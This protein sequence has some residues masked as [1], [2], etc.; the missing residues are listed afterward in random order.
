MIVIIGEEEAI[1]NA[2]LRAAELMVVSAKTAPKARG[3]DNVVSL[4]I[5]DKDVLEKLAVKMEELSLLH[6]DFFKRDAACIRKSDAVVLIGCKIVDIKL[7][8]TNETELDP[9]LVNSIIN[10]G[11]AIGSAVKIASM[12]NIDNRI[13]YTAGLAARELGLLS[14]DIVYGIPLSVKSKNIYFDRVWPPRS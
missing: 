10:L 5:T 2:V 9:N 7:K 6:G 3:V 1:K 12:L 13:M 14:A 4:V 11:I 8:K